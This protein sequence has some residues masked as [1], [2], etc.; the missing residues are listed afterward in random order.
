MKHKIETLT[1]FLTQTISSWS[2]VE[3]ITVDPRSEI[4]PY[5]PYFA[6]V[7][8]VYHRGKIPSAR[9]RRN[10]FGDPGAFESSAGRTKD[11]F[12]L[13]ELPIRIEYKDVKAINL[14]VNR[15]LKNIKLLKN[16]GTYA[17]FRL[18]NNKVILDA[19]GWIGQMRKA[20][21]TFPDKAW[22][23]LRDNYNS[24]MEHYLSDM[25]AASFS[26]DKFFLLLSEAEFLRYA[27]AS[28]FAANMR[29]EPSH[30][31]IEEHLRNLPSMPEGFWASWDSVLQK[32]GEIP[33]DKRF[34][35]AR[36][37]AGKVLSFH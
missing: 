7:I 12:F 29:F 16:S 6:V 14:L 18:M 26:N 10:A 5:D 4:F 2:N 15:P 37:L 11:R 22:K 27:A 19:H 3:C 30:R 24:K 17:F 33:A 9:S 32:E 23:A 8:D 31:D 34:E 21:A 1:N 35:I 20:L 13:E 25:G 36:I 28:V